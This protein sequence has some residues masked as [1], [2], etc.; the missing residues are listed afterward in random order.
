MSPAT[1][2]R[3]QER[4]QAFVVLAVPLAEDGVRLVEEQRRAVGVDLAEDNRLGGRDHLPRIGG[5]QLDDF[6][7]ACLPGALL[8]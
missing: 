4:A 3:V 2:A 1:V 5:E 8:G 7:Q 6:E